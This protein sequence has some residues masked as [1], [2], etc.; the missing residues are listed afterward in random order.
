[1]A[2]RKSRTL[3]EVELEFMQI[4][5]AGEEVSRPEISATLKEQ[6][7]NLPDGAIRTMLGILCDKG[8]ATRRPFGRTFLYKARVDEATATRSMVT[9]ILTRAFR[10]STSSMLAAVAESSTARRG[11]IKKLRGLIDDIR[12][13]E[14]R[15]KRK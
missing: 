14:G 12:Q 10:G 9:D 3:T 4:I 7:R 11:D 13:G 2:R 8:Y 6:G 1:M 15:K 5:W